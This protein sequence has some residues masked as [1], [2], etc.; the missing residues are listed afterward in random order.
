MKLLEDKAVKKAIARQRKKLARRMAPKE[1]Q[2]YDGAPLT[3]EQKQFGDEARKA[4][5]SKL[6]TTKEDVH[7]VIVDM[8]DIS[9]GAAAY[10]EAEEPEFF[11]RLNKHRFGS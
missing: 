7:V 11:A 2:N 6:G 8:E 4:V 1:V 9:R 5:A 3:D 10:L